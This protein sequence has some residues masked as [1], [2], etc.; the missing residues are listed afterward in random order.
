MKLKVGDLVVI[1]EGTHDERMPP[2]RT[3]LIVEAVR[4]PAW[5][6]D[7]FSVG[8]FR[9]M[10]TNGELLRFHEMFLKKV[11]QDEQKD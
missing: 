9:V 7:R 3:G 4:E 1:T 10:M 6:E 5:N 11:E 8:I 2:S